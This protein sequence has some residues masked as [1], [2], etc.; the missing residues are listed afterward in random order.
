MCTYSYLSLLIPLT[1]FT[2][3]YSIFENDERII[4]INSE[5]INGFIKG[6]IYNLENRLKKSILSNLYNETNLT[7][8]VVK[9]FK[10]ETNDIPVYG[11]EG[12][13]DS[14]F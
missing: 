3:Y 6:D 1:R 5:S 2:Y 9:N 7:I 4:N 11:W 12:V 10:V 8:V 14:N 13:L